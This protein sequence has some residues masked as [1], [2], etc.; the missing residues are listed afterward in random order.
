MFK[1]MRSGISGLRQRLS[2]TQNTIMGGVKNAP[3]TMSREEFIETLEESLITSDMGVATSLE[4]AEFVR[5]KGGQNVTR[6]QEY[7]RDYLYEILKEVEAPLKIERSPFMILVLGVNGVG[8]TT[9]IGKLSAHLSGSG[10][11][12]ILGAGDTF[13]AAAGEQ[14]ELWGKR[15]G[16]DVIRQSAG[17]DPGAVAFDTIKAAIGRYANI[18]LLDTAGRLHTKSNLMDEL[19]KITRISERELTGAPH[20]KLLVLD[21]STGQ[22]A[23][24]QA[25]LFND[26]I[27]VTGIV[28]TKLDGTAKGGIIVPLAKELK[29]PI[30]YIGV[31]EGVEDLRE[32]NAREFVEAV[33]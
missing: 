24:N 17:T 29:I 19:K 28:L 7:L 30:R 16:C 22:N 18:I 32:F 33:I 12:V 8:K 31:G 2:K 5:S 9:T 10:K 14:L 13:R 23:L 21:A 3:P 6:L 20:E 27:G 25:R 11:K 15:T 1:K 4:I 26:A